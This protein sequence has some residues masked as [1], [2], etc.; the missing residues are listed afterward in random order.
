MRKVLILLII[1]TLLASIPLAAANYRP[2]LS[3]I[4]FTY[5]KGFGKPEGTPGKGPPGGE[6]EYY[7]FLGKGVKWKDLPI[8][9]VINPDNP[10]GLS[11]SFVVEAINSA[12]EEWDD[13]TSAGL[14]G[15]YTVDYSAE[16]DWE[17][18][19]YTN[20]L[21]FGDYPEDGV[22]AVAVVWGYFYGPPKQ[23]EIIEF[24]IMF[25]IDFTWGYAGPTDETSLGDTSVMDLQNIVTHELG[26]GVGLA[27]LYDDECSEQTMYG[28]AE[29]GET[30]KRTLNDG[31]IAG[32]QELYGK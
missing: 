32:I 22:I 14:F 20:E 27:D 3:K 8:T 2:P 28:Y 23:R 13:H 15:T 24:D 18:P 26:H 12:V 31:D 6:K 19:D 7:E 30:K 17:S 4:V 5:K 11:M 16:V 10:D 1:A 9:Y 29:Y 21:A 25:D